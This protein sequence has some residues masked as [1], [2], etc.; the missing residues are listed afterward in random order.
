VKK[1][2]EDDGYG[3]Q[4]DM[5]VKLMAVIDSVSDNR[6]TSIPRFQ[7]LILGKDVPGRQSFYN[8]LE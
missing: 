6:P 4:A 2:K 3:S 7:K 5:I 1:Y 8:A